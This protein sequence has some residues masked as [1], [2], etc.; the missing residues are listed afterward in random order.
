MS[1]VLVSSLR[2]VLV[3]RV[4]GL[5]SSIGALS[6][7]LVLVACSGAGGSAPTP[8]FAITAQP[9]DQ[10]TVAGEP[11]TFSVTANAAASVQWYRLDGGQWQPLPGATQASYTVAAAQASDNGA[12]FHAVLTSTG[13]ARAVTSSN[14]TLTVVAV[15][16]APVVTVQPVAI[17]LAAGQAGSMS[18]TAS[19]TT[20]S[21]QWQRSADGATFADVDGATAATLALGPVSTADDGAIFRVVVSN[22]IGRVDSATARLMVTPAPVAPTFSASPANVSAVAG[23]SAS[24]DVV[25]SGTPVPTL[26]WQSSSDGDTWTPLAGQTNASLVLPAVA[27]GDDGKRFRAV[28]TNASGTVE[29]AAATLRVAPAPVAPVIAAQPADDSV[30][31]GG[32]PAFHVAATGTPTPT[33]Q[34]QLSTDGGAAFVNINGA[35]SADLSLAAAALVDD[36]KKLR[37]VVQNISGTVTSRVAT[38]TVRP[39]PH[40]ALQ[41]QPQ[42][43][44]AGLVPPQF[45]VGAAGAGLSYRWQMSTNGGAWTDIAGATS[46]SVAI[47][48]PPVDAAVRAVVTDA[49]GDTATSDAAALTHLNWSYLAPKPSDDMM[50]AL[51]WLDATH[52]VAVGDAGSVLASAD[53]GSSWSV[54]A[55]Q[56]VAHAQNLY[57]LDFGSATVGVAV[58]AQ[59][60]VRRTVDG[61]QHWVTVRAAAAGAPDLL[62]VAFSDAQTAVAVGR[63]ATMLRSTDGGATWSSVAQAGMTSSFAGI[64]FRAGVEIVI[65]QGGPALRSI[66]GGAQW[67]PIPAVTMS[68]DAVPTIAFASDSVVVVGGAGGVLRSSDAG[69]TWQSVTVGSDFNPGEIAFKDANVGYAPGRD[70]GDSAY[71]TT[72]GGASWTLITT[73]PLFGENDLRFGAGG[74]LL[75]A[76]TDGLLRS[77]DGGTSWTNALTPVFPTD[78]YLD[79]AAFGTSTTGVAGGASAL[80]RT[81]DGGATW[82]TVATGVAPGAFGWRAVRFADAST[83]YALNY[84]GRVVA[85]SDAGATWSLRGVAGITTVEGDMAFANASLGLVATDAGTMQRTTDGGTTWTTVNGSECFNNVVFVSS[86][87][88]MAG[89]CAGDILRSADAGVTWQTVSPMQHT[90]TVLGFADANVGIAVAPSLALGRGIVRRTTDGGATWQT[91]AVGTSDADEWFL[92]AWFQTPTEGYIVST[93]HVYRTTDGGVTWALDLFNR[94]GMA[95]GIALDARTSLMI[96]GS[97]VMRRTE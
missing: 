48:P 77:A 57:G 5:L 72:D 61:G 14:A 75:A 66:N 73:W 47:S 70:R 3:A 25:V 71:Q 33:Y 89:G 86:S 8:A 80:Y 90:A 92:N 87:V 65:A 62:S 23:Q 42:A 52:V 31:I 53:G 16:Q 6:L 60:L 59:G 4:C 36:G 17:S 55:E 12:Q 21:Y 91:I 24:F 7:S 96:G 74:V 64:A 32:T 69:L 82:A 51:R 56:D 94:D 44:H 28:A 37:V 58:G 1:A 39:A 22:S 2:S 85:S 27:V 35:T 11:V 43:W 41:P 45:E 18:V 15:P 19:G 88:A 84:D 46:A 13:D 9:A 50:R 68:V 81:T 10:T 54:V 49:T 93:Q 76:A 79:T 34:W 26:A 38:L 30:G 63:S 20:L 78:A 67:T 83:V 95:P 40:I 97:S 29:S